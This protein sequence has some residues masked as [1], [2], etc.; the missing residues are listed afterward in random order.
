MIYM[1]LSLKCQYSESNRIESTES[2]DFEIISS[3]IIHI[4]K[5]NISDLCSAEC[6]ETDSLLG[7]QNARPEPVVY[8][9]RYYILAIL[10]IFSCLSVS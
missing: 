4:I 3:I 7:Q 9:S 2:N 5:T 6:T 1:N 8:K 10:S